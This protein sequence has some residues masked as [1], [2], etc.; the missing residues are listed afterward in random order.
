LPTWLPDTQAPHCRTHTGR[1]AA[2]GPHPCP[3]THFHVRHG[4]I[5]AP[6]R[7]RATG[8]VQRQ[9]A[10]AGLIGWEVTQISPQGKVDAGAP[11]IRCTRPP[12]GSPLDDKSRARAERL[13]IIDVKAL[14]RNC[15]QHIGQRCTTADFTAAI[16][17]LQSRIARL[18]AQLALRR[19]K[20]GAPAGAP[21]L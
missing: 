9:R 11:G 1:D 18:E 17:R 7:I 3:A 21:L 2:K 10:G 16:T 8:R 12:R 5:H 14:D 6:H 13:L 20:K 19:C 15:P 4:A